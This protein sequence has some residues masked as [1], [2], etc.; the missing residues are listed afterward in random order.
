LLSP[1]SIIFEHPFP[2][3]KE[4]V[5]HITTH[6]NDILEFKYDRN[7]YTGVD[8]YYN[9]V[10]EMIK[11]EENIEVDTI[12]FKFSILDDSTK[13]FTSSKLNIIKELRFVMRLA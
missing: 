10:C 4:K 6:D 7:H 5:I 9:F 11:K 8:Q 1:N 12:Q 13:M 2:I 3:N